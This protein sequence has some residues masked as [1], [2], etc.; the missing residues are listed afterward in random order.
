[1]IHI[2]LS[3]AGADVGM[4]KRAADALVDAGFEVWWDD[5]LPAHRSFHDV[6]DERLRAADAVLVLWSSTA[7]K[8]DWV[9][10]EAD[11]ARKH[12]N[13]VQASLDGDLPPMPFE[14]IQ[15]AKLT[16][17]KG[18]TAHSEWMKVIDSVRAVAGGVSPREDIPAPQRHRWRVP[19]WTVVAAVVAVSLGVGA[20]YLMRTASQQ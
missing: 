16:G 13:L 2:F 15:C 10:S 8:S 19:R 14:Q 17:W 18:E 3:P 11:F 6:I 1:M 12:G 20:Y 7:A 5:H 4:A 9:R